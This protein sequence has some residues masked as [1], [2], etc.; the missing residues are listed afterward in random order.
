[1]ALFNSRYISFSFSVISIDILLLL[2]LIILIIYEDLLDMF[3]FFKFCSIRTLI[4]HDF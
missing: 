1:M 3:L 2:I 4:T